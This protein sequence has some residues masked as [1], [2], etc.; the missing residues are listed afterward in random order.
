MTKRVFQS[1]WLW[2]LLSATVTAGPAR[3]VQVEAEQVLGTHLQVLVSS[4]S[5][6]ESEVR[7]S[8]MAEIERLSAIFNTRDPG[9]EAARVARVSGPQVVTAELGEV[10]ALARRLHL[11]TNGR[12]SPGVAPLLVASASGAGPYEIAA[13]LAEGVRLADYT[14]EQKADG[15]WMFQREATGPLALDAVAK[16][17]IVDALADHFAATPGVEAV[18][19]NIGG[20][21]ARRGTFPG[22]FA[23]IINPR[24]AADNAGPLVTL[25]CP[26]A[27]ATSGGYERPAH[28]LDARSGRPADG[29]LSAS[30]R[31]S[32]CAE[33]DALAT[34][35]CLMPPAEG[36][37]LLERHPGSDAL[38]VAADGSVHASA[39]WPG[40]VP[41]DAPAAPAGEIV[42][43]YEIINSTPD[44]RYHK[45]YVSVWIE[46]AAGK[47]LRELG[48]YG[49]KAKHWSSLRTWWATGGRDSAKD[50]DLI[51]TISGASRPAGRH[52]LAWDG[53]DNAGQPVPPGRV[54]VCVEVNREKGPNR[55]SPTLDRIAIDLAQPS[56]SVKGKSQPELGPTSVI[57]K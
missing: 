56:F 17:W 3:V 40:A 55:S 11:E 48:L 9:S 54:F 47:H 1:A 22:L 6:S 34:A 24:A 18:L 53:K 26:V 46:D 28:L 52:R 42:I 32:T 30:V 14:V 27:L 7:A 39:G 51:S 35:L 21:I 41:L 45:P 50:R 2:L 44:L 16:G 37:R 29:V 15:S 38:I 25:D 57:R 36:L 31:A 23:G 43:E 20:E 13:A 12:F 10:L 19:V 4:P 8:A 33:A 5:L 49:K